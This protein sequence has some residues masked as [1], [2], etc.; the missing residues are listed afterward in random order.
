M[1]EPTNAEPG[2]TA[3]TGTM[4]RGG[5]LDP[6]LAEGRSK[7]LLFASMG[8]LGVGTTLAVGP[9]VWVGIVGIG[10]AFIVNTVGKL[11]HYAGLPLARERRL[12]LSASWLLLA[13]AVIGLL[14]TYAYGRYGPGAGSY[15]WSLAAAGLGFGLLHVAAQ[16]RYLPGR[17]VDPGA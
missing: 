11:R 16:G 10:V 15:F 12:L 4:G 8:A 5:W 6:S 14:A 13:A 2:P 9:V 3:D 1:S 7:L 17:D